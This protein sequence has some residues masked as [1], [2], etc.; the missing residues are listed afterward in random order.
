MK[1]KL[2]WAVMMLLCVGLVS[3]NDD[4]D[5]NGPSTPP[6]N[7]GFSFVSGTE[8]STFEITYPDGTTVTTGG[9]SVNDANGQLL[10]LDYYR[11]FLISTDTATFF[12]RISIPQDTA[13]SDAV[14]K[15]HTLFPFRLDLQDTGGMTEVFSEFYSISGSPFTGNAEGTIKISRD[16]TTALGI[17][18]VIGEVD[19]TFNAFTS[20]E[21]N[22]EGFFWAKE[23]PW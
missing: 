10:D 9:T 6:S 23:F 13:S 18:S 2:I 20:Q 14:N 5:D 4:D 21:T 3:C 8:G 7:T 16:V 15:D 11:Q 12:F 1:N 22:V 19:A 17:Y